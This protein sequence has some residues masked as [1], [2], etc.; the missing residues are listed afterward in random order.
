MVLLPGLTRRSSEC[1]APLASFNG[2]TAYS[3]GPDMGNPLVG[4]NGNSST[5]VEYDVRNIQDRLQYPWGLTM[6]GFL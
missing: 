2:V 6:L 4:C 5:G 3:N 1:G